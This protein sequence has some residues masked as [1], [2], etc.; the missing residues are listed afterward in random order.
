MTTDFTILSGRTVP[1]N[2]T[3]DSG[4]PYLTPT[5]T[6]QAQSTTASITG[7]APGLT[8]KFNNNSISDPAPN[9]AYSLVSYLWNF[10]DYYN[11]I[12]NRT[13]S[14]SANSFEHTYIMPGKYTVSLTH[15]QAI[16]ETQLDPGS[17]YCNGKYSINWYW[18]NLN[19][20]TVEQQTNIPD[21]DATN[22]GTTYAKTWDDEI[23]CF[24][25]HCRYWS[26]E[27]LTSL[28]SNTATWEQ[29]QTDAS[30]E[31]RWQVEA[32]DE[33]C[34][35]TDLASDTT[36]D[37]ITQTTT[38]SYIVEVI[39]IPP[40]AGIYSVTRPPFSSSPAVIRLTSRTTTCGSFPIDRI[41]WDFADGSPIKSVTR[42]GA[43]TDNSLIYNNYFSADKADPRN[44]DV[45]HTYYSNNEVTSFA[46]Y[47]SLTA[48][49]ANTSTT[50]ARSTTIGPFSKSYNVVA[51][52]DVKLIKVKNTIHG[53][54]YT[55]SH[56]NACSFQ[57]T[58]PILSTEEDITEDNITGR[59]IYTGWPR[60]VNLL[61]DNY[62][63]PPLYSGNRGADYTFN[64]GIQEFITTEEDID[65]KLLEQEDG[66]L[67]ITNIN[68]DTSDS[69]STVIEPVAEPE[70]IVCKNANSYYVLIELGLWDSF[71]GVDPAGLDNTPG[72]YTVIAR[73]CESVKAYSEE[74]ENAGN[75]YDGDVVELNDREGKW[76]VYT[77]FTGTGNAGANTP[78]IISINGQ[79][80]KYQ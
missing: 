21:W 61:E 42:A 51:N 2:Y 74:T 19:C 50:S 75:F 80:V 53:N 41:D 55:I 29:T 31:K 33:V 5:N 45:V 30:L 12:D 13:S 58:S 6:A 65:N 20:N 39:E 9:N 23:G 67:F 76:K 56:N 25:R 64:V 69:G 70:E 15:S 27:N 77:I 52:E 4:A 48:Y 16:T 54:L 71:D 10:G 49:A 44:Y 72:F 26:W 8:V 37:A 60:P 35:N 46:Y 66:D 63:S 1:Q 62:N 17:N 78:L 73:G 14:P 36:I 32:N 59:R 40:V 34:T 38:K 43:N 28:R 11:S 22:K 7:Y 47:P 18:D 79:N 24:E 68:N 57:T 3:W